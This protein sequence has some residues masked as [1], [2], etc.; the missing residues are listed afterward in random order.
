[1]SADRADALRLAGVL[2]RCDPLA[3]RLDRV[4]ACPSCASVRARWLDAT[5]ARSTA[6]AA[7]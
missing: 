7:S 1:M 6:R 5:R 4:V 2:C 3:H